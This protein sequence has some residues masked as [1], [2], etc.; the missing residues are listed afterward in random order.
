MTQIWGRTAHSGAAAAA[1]LCTLVAGG[2]APSSAEPPSR[3]GAR[4]TATTSYPS[5]FVGAYKHR[6]AVYHSSNGTFSHFLTPA[7]SGTDS[8]LPSLSPGRTTVFYVR[9]SPAATCIDTYRVPLAG[10]A[11]KSVRTGEN[12]GAQPIASGPYGAL[13]GTYACI[14]SR[15]VRA[16]A[17]NKKSYNITGVRNYGANGLSWNPDGYRLA[18]ATTSD[19]VR[20]FDVRT[21]S[22]FTLGKLVPC[23]S[24]MSGCVTHA[25]SYSPSGVLYYVAV[26]GS[27]VKVVKLSS[28][29][30]IAVFSLP[31]TAA[32]YSLAAGPGSNVL[33]SGD[34]DSGTMTSSYF[35][36]RWDGSARHT[37]AHSAV[38]VDW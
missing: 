22:D 34:A 15:Y 1:I 14:A 5:T 11:I 12:G 30:G 4:A 8:G 18:V 6:L 26:K 25:P 36:V 24:G 27:T 13:A 31:R 21:T 9:T 35:V 20:Y 2:A 23:P 7:V 3:S 16:T 17:A 10:G 19:G 37:L 29:K 33:A 38:Q 32:H 28:G